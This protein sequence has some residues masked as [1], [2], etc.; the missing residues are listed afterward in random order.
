MNSFSQKE[1]L[2]LLIFTDGQLVQWI[3][4]SYFSYKDKNGIEQKIY[5][6]YYL[7]DIEIDI[8][9]YQKIISLESGFTEH[10]GN[11]GRAPDSLFIRELLIIYIIYFLKDR[12]SLFKSF[13]KYA[14]NIQSFFYT[15]LMI[16]ELF[17][18]KYLLLYI[19]TCLSVIYNNN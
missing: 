17:F 12:S 13:K 10:C 15:T 5:F 3:D 2:N 9:H 7:G 14:S 6:Y 1:K 4:S 16:W 19:F 11:T 8:D 18:I